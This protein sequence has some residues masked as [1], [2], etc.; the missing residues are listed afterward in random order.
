MSSKGAP[1]IDCLLDRARV[2]R[3]KP[4]QVLPTQN[5]GPNHF[6]PQF[7]FLAGGLAPAVAGDE[8]D[9]GEVPGSLD[10]GS[11]LSLL[12]G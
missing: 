12:A 6:A 8:L 2:Y 5:R 1:E 9:Q 11:Q 4:L 10:S 3:S 7:C